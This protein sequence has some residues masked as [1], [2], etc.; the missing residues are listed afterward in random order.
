MFGIKREFTFKIF[1]IL[2]RKGLALLQAAAYIQQ[3]FKVGRVAGE[4]KSES[5]AEQDPILLEISDVTQ[6]LKNIRCRFDFEIESDM[7]EACIFE[8]RALLSRYSHLL[9]LAKQKGLCQSPATKFISDNRKTH[10]I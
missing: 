6:K 9:S 5:T 2:I 7:I 8:E 4:K 1:H 10:N 3:F